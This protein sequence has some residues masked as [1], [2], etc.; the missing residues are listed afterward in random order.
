MSSILLEMGHSLT[1]GYLPKLRSSIKSPKHDSP[2]VKKYLNEI[3]S[4]H[5]NKKENRFKMI[6][7]S[8]FDSDLSH[9][10]ISFLKNRAK[11]DTIF[12]LRKENLD[13]NE[14]VVKKEFDFY[15]SQGFETAK[16]FQGF[17]KTFKKNYDI[18]IFLN[19]STFDT[20]ITTYLVN[21]YNLKFNCIEKFSFRKT[22]LI[23]HQGN[24]RTFS[25][26]ELI[27]K[28]RQSIGLLEKK[29]IVKIRNCV[30]AQ[31]KQRMTGNNDLWVTVTQKKK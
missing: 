12:C 5:K 16:S 24:I 10:D 18:F 21:K 3:L 8:D 25:D 28:N 15:L 1:I 4:K 17:L 14:H 29:N 6:D 13:F 20:A 22:R 30:K 23:N 19:G 27:W 9:L 2:N 11:L 7:L 26:L 31:I